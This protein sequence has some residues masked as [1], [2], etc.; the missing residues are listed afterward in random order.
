MHLVNAFRVQ[1][2][3]ELAICTNL[4]FKLIYQQLLPETIQSNSRVMA[5]LHDTGDLVT[6]T[7]SP[8]AYF[9]L[10][11]TGIKIK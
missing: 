3:F 4:K 9:S 11:P 8:M 2:S 1:G 7:L 5:M 10:P 6:L